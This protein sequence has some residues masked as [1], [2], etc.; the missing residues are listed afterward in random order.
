MSIATWNVNSWT[1]ENGKIREDIIR[2][3]DVDI[4]LLTETKLSHNLEITMNNYK[5]FGKNRSFI[6]KTAKCASGGV[7]ILVKSCIANSHN[8]QVSDSAFDGILSLILTNKSTERQISVTVCYLPPDRSQYGR[9]TQAFFDHLL[10]IAYSA[11][12]CD[13]I[14]MGGDFNSRVGKHLDYIPDVD[15]ICG[16]RPLDETTNSHGEAFIEYLKESKQCIVNGRITPHLDNF[17]SISGRGKA[18]VDYLIVN[19]NQIEDV[20]KCQVLPVRTLCEKLQYKP[21]GKLPDHSIVLAEMQ[22]YPWEKE[23]TLHCSASNPCS[24]LPSKLAHVSKVPDGFLSSENCKQMIADTIHRIE[25][26]ESSQT[27]V[28]VRYDEILSIYEE[29]TH[30]HFPTSK[31]SKLKKNNNFIAKPWW[32]K[33]LQLIGGIWLLLRDSF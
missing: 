30:H 3:L 23:Q 1:T 26:L 9:D 24:N 12:D 18:V 22:Y 17:T 15:S 21:S 14:V 27:E 2:K 10:Q 16:R 25:H 7:G 32:M 6:K 13:L 33:N 5:W 28:G 19:H 8:I 29:E 20:I 31:N 4:V 11:S